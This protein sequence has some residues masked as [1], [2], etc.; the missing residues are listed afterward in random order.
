MIS[1]KEKFLFE[2][3]GE[4]LMIDNKISLESF[5]VKVEIKS[6]NPEH[7]Y[8]IIENL[9]AILSK[10]IKAYNGV[11]TDLF[12]EIK[13]SK[14]GF[15]RI[16]K[17]SELVPSEEKSENQIIEY[18]LHQLRLCIAEHSPSK[19]FVHAGVIGWN[20]QAFVFPGV[21]YSGKTT[22]VTE[23]IKRG[24][25]Y[26]SD[27]YAVFDKYGFV[28]PFSKELSI[29]GFSREDEREEIP[30]EK[31]GG[32]VGKKPISVKLVFFTEYEKEANWKPIKLSTGRALLELIPHT[33][34]I[35]RDPKNTIKFLNKVL[36][37]AIIAKS[38]RS[39][40]EDFV[41]SILKFVAK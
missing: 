8:K 5:G 34:P 2:Q 19:V 22:I 40:A 27:E 23:F 11:N 20:N 37:R 32:I 7:L 3:T 26:Y 14:K 18:F 38:K 36:N 41:N 39:N 25:I 28:H 21:S 16:L 31:L 35:R 9:P 10:N 29:R 13:N 33:L 12:F 1:K 4:S 15:Y 17:N 6:D 30:V 24:A